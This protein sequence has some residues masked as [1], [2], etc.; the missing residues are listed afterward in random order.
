MFNSVPLKRSDGTKYHV[1]T[2]KPASTET[3]YKGQTHFPIN[4]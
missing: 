2:V 1:S 3:V 4:E